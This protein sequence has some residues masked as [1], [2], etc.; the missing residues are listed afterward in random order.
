MK[1]NQ[2]DV[3]ENMKVSRSIHL[4][5]SEQIL[6]FLT[7]IPTYC[8]FNHHIRIILILI[9]DRMQLNIVPDSAHLYM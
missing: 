8:S 3:T 2:K 1:E 9:T 7:V 4:P 5:F 6:N